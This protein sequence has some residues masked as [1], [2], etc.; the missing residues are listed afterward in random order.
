MGDSVP[1]IQCKV[2]DD[3]T[4]CNDR[5]KKYIAKVQ[6]WTV[7]KQTSEAS[8]VLKILGNPMSDDLRDWARRRLHIL[9]LVTAASKEEGQDL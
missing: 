1:A 7:D 4:D 9:E 6:A 5:E 3:M 8:R 2:D